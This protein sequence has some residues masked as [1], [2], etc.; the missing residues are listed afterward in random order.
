MAK[1]TQAAIDEAGLN[2]A[3]YAVIEPVRSHSIA[4]RQGGI[5][6]PSAESGVAQSPA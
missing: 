6:R 3:D 5:R 4:G 2:D 1:L